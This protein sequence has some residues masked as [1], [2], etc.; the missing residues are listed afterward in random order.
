MQILPVRSKRDRAFRHATK[1]TTK[2]TRTGKNGTWCVCSAKNTPPAWPR[3]PASLSSPLARHF[4]LAPRPRANLE[5]ATN[6]LSASVCMLS[7]TIPGLRSNSATTRTRSG[8]PIPVL[9]WH[10]PSH[11]WTTWTRSRLTFH[12][13]GFDFD[14]PSSGFDSR[15]A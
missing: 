9:D 6:Q 1:P 13:D 7:A 5:L 15:D 14:T 11:N 2:P 8:H 12:H 10:C 4:G 3:R